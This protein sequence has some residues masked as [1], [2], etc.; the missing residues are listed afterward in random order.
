MA[1]RI[2]FDRYTAQYN[3]LLRE[4]TTFFSE[5]DAYFAKYKAAW[6]KARVVKP[7]ERVLEYGCGIG[8]NIPFL[9]DAFPAATVV[10]TD[11]SRASL[12]VAR[13]QN[14]RV[15]FIDACQEVLGQDPFDLILVAGVFH[16]IPVSERPHICDQLY[17]LLRASGELFVFEHNPYNPVTR[18]IVSQCAYDDDAV[19]LAPRELRRLL[20]D[21]GFNQ[22]QTAYCLFVPP[23]FAKLAW[24]ESRLEWLPLG[25]QYV[26]RV[27]K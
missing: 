15:E 2:D 3:R 7:V 24:L 26:V 10:G 25:G 20:C 9:I 6:I 14:P 13:Q 21:S 8:R 22:P 23:R 17:G 12:E 27:S 11:I 1:N 5:D 16:H 4:G 19:L 18:R